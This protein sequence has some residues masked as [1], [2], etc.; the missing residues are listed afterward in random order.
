MNDMDSS[1]DERLRDATRAV[2]EGIEPSA[3]AWSEIDGRIQKSHRHRA[4]TTW[5]VALLGLASVA[6]AVAVSAALLLT[7]DDAPAKRRVA[8]RWAPSVVWQR[9]FAPPVTPT[10]LRT[11]AMDASTVFASDGFAEPSVVRALN[12]DTGA[13][14]WSRQFPSAAFI[15]GSAGG[16]I[17]IGE[18]YDRITGLDSRTG[19]VR[20]TVDLRAE[21]LAGYGAVVS[22]ILPGTSVIGL[23]ANAEG[24]VRPPVIVGLNLGSGTIRWRTPLAD[25]TDLT[26]AA[27]VGHRERR[28][29]PDHV[30]P[31]GERARQRGLRA[32]PWRRH[33]PLGGPARRR[34]RIR[35]GKRHRD[36]RRN[37]NPVAVGDRHRCCHGWRDLM[38]S[39]GHRLRR[40]CRVRR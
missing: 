27:T 30:E 37:P 31:P 23:S 33:S 34:P 12:R 5:R 1:V 35:I 19:R 29:V 4:T 25:G 28:S 14:R 17:V 7:R 3:R 18:Q 36:D 10:F 11:L 26:F 21:G 2:A 32:R 15:Q 40:C 39:A 20:W 6:L 24:D 22:A 38:A 16:V 8:H 13:V 9:R